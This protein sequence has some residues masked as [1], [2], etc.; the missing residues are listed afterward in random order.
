MPGATGIG[1]TSRLGI[2]N[3]DHGRAATDLPA[4][5]R[6]VLGPLGGAA[7]WRRVALERA[8][9]FDPRWFLYWE[10]VD[11]ALRLDRAGY[12]CRTVPDAH[13]LHEGSG[14]VGKWSTTNVFYMVRNHWPCLLASLPGRLLVHH[15]LALL[16]APRRA[17]VLYARRG[18]PLAAL[19]GLVC[20]ALLVPGAILSRRHLPRSGSGVKAAARITELLVAADENRALLKAEA[21][22]ERR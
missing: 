4:A 22:R 8:G 2:L 16:L 14:T 20:G 12:E 9:N 19:A 10:D 6:T 5:S 7:L 18:R 3:L 1:L 11:I 21:H 17:S 13:V 15:M